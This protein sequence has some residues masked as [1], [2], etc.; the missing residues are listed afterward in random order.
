MYEEPWTVST[1]EIDEE[2]AQ[3]IVDFADS[4]GYD[5]HPVDPAYYYIR[6]MDRGTV[7]TLLSLMRAGLESKA[8]EF[9][10]PLRIGGQSMIDDMEDW[11][12]QAADVTYD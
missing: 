1:P 9:L 7:E 2:G 5:A 4:L 12:E 8:L 6:Y 3:K 10:D 11:L